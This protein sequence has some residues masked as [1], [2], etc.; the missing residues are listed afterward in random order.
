V[1]EIADDTNTGVGE[2]VMETAR[3]E[4]PVVSTNTDVVVALFVGTGSLVCEVTS[5]E[6]VIVVPAAVLPF[7]V[8]TNVK[9][10]VVVEL[11]KLEPSVQITWPVPPTAGAVPQV[12]PVGGVIEEKVVLG[13]VC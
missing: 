5:A 11:F 4:S 10:V 9:V 1:Y 8:T 13:G 2:A 3:S 12:H 7:T 6:F